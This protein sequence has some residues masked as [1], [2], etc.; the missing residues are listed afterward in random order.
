MITN[1]PR[2]RRPGHS[3]TR[4]QIL[5]SALTLFSDLGYQKVSLRAIA[6]HADV[7]PALIHHYFDSKAD[8]FAEAVVD[9]GL[10]EPEALVQRITTGPVEQVGERAASV[11]V[12]MW[13]LP[14]AH[15]RFVAM[16]RAAVNEPGHHRPFS[17]YLAIEL[18]GKVA[19]T[20]GHHNSRERGQL[21][22]TLVIGFLMGRD[23]MQLPAL[24][25]GSRARTTEA[26]AKA[27][28]VY[29]ADPW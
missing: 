8:L 19:E 24:A 17:E 22:V 9:V 7:D 20:L 11:L 21:A 15:E 3:D 10:P 27:M 13:S 1:R 14:G 2:G 4:R 12:E 28:Q 26:L 16:L 23:V 5:E 6:R 25:R 18:Y 29:L